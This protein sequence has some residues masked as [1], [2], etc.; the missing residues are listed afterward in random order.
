MSNG[1]RIHVP[2]VND[3]ELVRNQLV[4]DKKEFYLYHTSTTRPKN[5]ALF[6]LDDMSTDDLRTL[7]AEVNVSPADIKK[8]SLKKPKYDRQAVYLLYF[9]PGAG[10]LPELR[11]IRSINH[12][13]VR[14]ELF[15]PRQ[16]D[17]IPQ[18]WNCQR[19]GHS[20]SNCQMQAKCLVCAEDHETSK[21]SKR[22]PKLNLKQQLAEPGASQPDR[23]FVKCADC[24]EQHTANYRGCSKRKE[25]I[26]IQEKL[27]HRNPRTKFADRQQFR[28]NEQD[29]PQPEYC[30]PAAPNG[31]LPSRL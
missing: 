14:W 5:I 18:C 22:V 9:L 17:K 21:C 16:H 23:S 1:I 30:T 8:L 4:A 25:Y 7:L 29:F 6:G 27:Q 19:L 24:G 20:S 28:Y 12:V 2:D 11:K 15:H 3:W 10:N 31:Q 13:M 26:S